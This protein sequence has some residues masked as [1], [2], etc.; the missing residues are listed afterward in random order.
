[1]GRIRLDPDD[2]MMRPRRGFSLA[3]V[4]VA[5]TILTTSLLGFAAIAQKF[6]RA[7]SDVLSRTLGSEIATARIEQIKAA[8]PYGTLVTTYHNV[9]ESWTGTHAWSG[10]S[11]RTLVTRTGPTAT[12]DYMTVTVI[13]SGRALNPV[14]RRTTSVAAF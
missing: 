14:I 2:T 11:R 3:E 9:T 7:N 5:M 1:M 12:A 13:V 10:F 8:R 4:I 6:T